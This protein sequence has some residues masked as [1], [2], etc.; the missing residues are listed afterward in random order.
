MRI[1]SHHDNLSARRDATMT[2]MIDVVFLLLIFFLCTASFQISEQML[3][4]AVRIASGEG[5]D[6]VDIPPELEDLEQIVVKILW[7]D[8]QPRWQVNREPKATL[9]QVA[10]VLTD[11]AAIDTAVP[12]IL[13]VAGP[14]PLEHVIEAYDVS[15]SIGFSKIQFAASA[16]VLR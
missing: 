5:T 1:P 12:V 15:R 10:D 4:S 14:V 2:P 7:Q 13:D 6:D 8:G 9:Q 3:P 16:E 11:A